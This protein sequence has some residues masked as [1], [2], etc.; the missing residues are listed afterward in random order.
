MRD[1]LRRYVPVIRTW[2]T[3]D[4]HLPDPYETIYSENYAPANAAAVLAAV[5]SSSRTEEA[6]KLL[7]QM[8]ARTVTLLGDKQGVTPFCRVF[9]Y[10]YGLMALLLA[11]EPDRSRLVGRFGGVLA[12]YEDDCVVVNTNCAA[13]QWSMELFTEMLGLRPANREL[14]RHRLTF[15]ARAQL[16][17]GFINDEVTEKQ[18]H[19]GMPIAYHAFTLFLLL[20]AIAMIKNWPEELEAERLEAERIIR[21]GMLW[22]RHTVTPDGAFAMI[23]RSSYQTFTWG[24]LTALLAYTAPGGEYGATVDAAFRNW[25]PY[26]HEDGTYGCTPNLLPHSLRV[27]FETYTHLNMY[28]LLGLT[29]I[30]VAERVLERGI[31]LPEAMSSEAAESDREL[32]ATMIDAESG[33]AFYRC[34]LHFFGC[35]M[36]MHNRQYAPVMQGFHF[37][38][39]GRKVPVAE[40]RLSSPYRLSAKRDRDDVWEGYAITDEAGL[41]HVPDMTHNVQLTA[42]SDGFRMRYADERLSCE[43]TITIG[44]DGIAWHYVLEVKQALRS[45]DHVLPLVVHD[46]RNPLRIAETPESGVLLLRTGDQSF[47]LRYEGTASPEM[48]LHRSILSVSGISAKVYARASGPLQPGHIVRWSV[49]LSSSIL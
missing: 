10:H 23:E 36:R 18:I 15:I 40:P 22:L 19:D 20:G 47:T 49:K 5:C 44:D 1:V 6:A 33:Y 8:L 48:E 11:P 28:N 30:A 32:D 25:L 42:E 46:G 2:T 43:K 24:A 37:R 12:A 16:G 17:S 7:E 45:I 9:L 21:S 3:P 13:L 26:A 34:G 14:L 38:L 27:G 4:G 35:T 31:R 41:V 29:G 39:D